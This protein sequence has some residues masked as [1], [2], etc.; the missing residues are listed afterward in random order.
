[1]LIGFALGFHVTNLQIQNKEPFI[2]TSKKNLDFKLS[3]SKKNIILIPGASNKSKCYPAIKFAELSKLLDANFIVIWGSKKEKLMAQ[4][5][6]ELSP[7]VN[8]CNELS[9]DSLICLISNS[10]LVIGPDTGPTHI[11]WALNIPSIT[12]F[13]STPGYRNTYVTK[14]NKILESESEVNPYKINKKDLSIKDI[15]ENKISELANRL[16]T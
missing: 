1:L 14:I 10:D 8:I 2:F 12:L 13:G 11:S 3:N 16:L 5:I 15:H 7:D 6:K 4:K 9:I